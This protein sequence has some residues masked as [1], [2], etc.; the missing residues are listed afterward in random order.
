MPLL[1]VTSLSKDFRVRKRAAGV[2]GSLRSLVVSEWE[3]RRAVREV[4]FEIGS[5]EIVGYLGPNGAGK[6][7][8]VKMLVGILQPTSG[9]V[10]LDGLDPQRHRTQVARNIGVVFGQ[11]TQ[12]WWDLPLIESFELLRHIYDLPPRRYRG[13]LNRLTEVLEMSD[14]LNVPVRLLSLGQRMRGDLAAALLHEP[15]VLLLDEP[16]IGLDILAKEQVRE[17]ILAMNRER[18][19][20]V[21]LTTHDLGDVER[22]CARVLIIDRGALIYDGGLEDLRQAYEPYR[23]LVLDLLDG[24]PARDA[25]AAAL[26]EF[27]R[28]DQAGAAPAIVREEG[29]RFAVR[30]DPR[31][32][33]APHL[34]S[35]LTARVALRDLAVEEAEIETVVARIY[36]EGM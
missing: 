16:T 14:F 2:W 9:S 26:R 22:L 8:T 34:I 36:R 1:Q 23:T 17:F 25:L 33:A 32:V 24:P 20:T 10:S 7:T 30:F 18:G 28:P 3:M 35:H 12:L 31:L 29:A 6:S 27:P 13:S 5:G 15:K 21:L 11:R 19:L 4:S